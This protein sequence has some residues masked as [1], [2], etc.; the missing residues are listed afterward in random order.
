MI[1]FNKKDAVADAI[2]RIL[3]Q[4]EAECVTKPEAKNIAKKE[5]KGHEKS[6]HHK[7]EIDV[8]D[9]TED[10][11]GGRVKTKR[12][13]D[14]GPGT[15]G[16]STKVRFHAGPKNEEYETKELT[17]GKPPATVK[18]AKPQ[19]EKMEDKE[20][21]RERKMLGMK[22]SISL[23]M[24]K[25]KYEE[26]S[27]YDDLINEVLS[28]DASAG[29][30]IHD[31]VH[32]D[33]P[34]FAGKSKEERKK[35]ALAAYY[36][37][38]K[39]EEVEQIDEKVISSELQTIQG[40]HVVNSQ[41]HT[42]PDAKHGVSSD[43][44]VHKGTI[45]SKGG[46]N[47]KKF[48]IH[49]HPNHGL[50]FKTNHT[51]D[52]KQSIKKHLI[53]NKMAGKG[54]AIHE[55]VEQ[56]EEKVLETSFQTLH[57]E[58]SVN[59]QTHTHPDAKHGVSIDTL[60]HKGNIKKKGGARK[61]F[62]VHNHVNRGLIFMTHH[63]D[64]EKK[65]IKDHLVKNKMAFKSTSISEEVEQIEE[66]LGHWAIK[67]MARLAN[68]NDLEWHHV[69][70][71]QKE[72]DNKL[73]NHPQAATIL[74]KH[75]KMAKDAQYHKKSDDEARQHFADNMQTLHNDIKSTH[76]VK[77]E[78]FEEGWDDMVK[79]A[80]DSVKSGPKPSGG[81][82][83]KKGSRYGGGKQADKPE[84]DDEKPVKEAK[85]PNMDAGVGSGPNFTKNE[86]KPMTVA[87]NLAKK[88]MARMKSE[89]LGKAPGNN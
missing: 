77:E 52:E 82:G 7:E 69:N 58:H 54:T 21:K 20:A 47:K 50:V 88:S 40:N 64:D 11:I 35:Q 66:G 16:K 13:D 44:L 30:W 32:S 53:Y 29:A 46:S 3:Q 10:M 26:S 17:K 79:S 83:V 15:D 85:D 14:V 31:F 18:T 68:K 67:Q 62:E 63:S 36:A 80:K 78:T 2:A 75:K 76:S 22:E 34:K 61:K 5:V 12:K 70:V 81:S 84:H 86:S 6:M 72:I 38:Q 39:N 27:I 49:N 28:K 19:P 9:R 65:A 24:F 4:E 41:T 51:D 55:E 71:A 74:N 8:N 42:H 37:K 45:S 59:S 48:E 33:N 23:K 1:N 73:K 57:G 87:K 25:E 56:I 43:T 60:V 89:M